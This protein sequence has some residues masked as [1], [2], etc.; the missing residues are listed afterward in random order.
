MFLS[1]SS[2]FHVSC[3][4]LAI[5]FSFIWQENLKMQRVRVCHQSMEDGRLFHSFH[6]LSLKLGSE[7]TQLDRKWMQNKVKHLVTWI[8]FWKILAAH[9]VN[10]KSTII[11]CSLYQFFCVM[12]SFWITYFQPWIWTIGKKLLLGKWFEN[13]CIRKIKLKVPNSGMWHGLQHRVPSI[14]AWKCC[15]F[16][17][18]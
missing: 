2:F 16:Q 12:F 11:Y 13:K 17:E 6:T 18:F 14:L 7:W 8:I 1:L 4:Q 5:K 15:A 10:S 3:T 9:L